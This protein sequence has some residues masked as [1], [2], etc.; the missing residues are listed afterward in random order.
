MPILLVGSLFPVGPP[1]K[2]A[3][4]LVEAGPCQGGRFNDFDFRVNLPCVLSRQFGLERDVRQQIDLVQ[5][6]QLRFTTDHWVFQRLVFAFGG[7]QHDD[8]GILAEI[9]AR[10]TDQVADVLNKQQIERIE[11]PSVE[12]PIDHPGV[13]VASAP[14]SDLS[15]RVT[16]P[17]KTN[18]VVLGLKVAREDADPCRRSELL[19][20][21]FQK[22][23]LARAWR[24]EE[25]PAQRAGLTEYR[26]QTIGNALVL[27]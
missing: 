20:R 26:A 16:V 4:P 17:P 3:E 23:G 15:H 24:T 1:G 22:R 2:P 18:G 27:T 12:M 5:D 10:G 6:H 14:G 21:T 9:V 7:A 13:K 19:K 25:G 8:L 11:V